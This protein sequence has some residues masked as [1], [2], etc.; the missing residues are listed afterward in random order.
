MV[1]LLYRFTNTGVAGGVRLSNTFHVRNPTAGAALTLASLN[2]IATAFDTFYS[3]NASYLA[4]AVAW[5]SGT[6]VLQY[7]I[8][9][10]TN[11]PTIMAVTP[12]TTTGGTGG[13]PLPSAVAMVLSWR[14]ALAGPSTRGR[15]FFGVLA[16]TTMTSGVFTGAITGTIVGRCA[17][18]I[19]NIKAAAGS[20]DLVVYSKVHNYT[21]NITSATI[22]AVPDNLSSRK[23]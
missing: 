7:D 20:P 19:T 6:R 10:P 2:T 14:T 8:D 1:N 13:D 5:T 17:L 15:T 9:S 3:S 16:K 21:T 18:L 11:P 22:D 23:Y 4:T 12:V